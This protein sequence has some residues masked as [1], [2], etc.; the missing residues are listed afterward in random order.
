MLNEKIPVIHAFPV[1][2]PQTQTWMYNQIKYL[3]ADIEVHVVCEQTRNLE[4]FYLPRM[5][6]LKTAS[7]LRYLWEKGIRNLGVRY[8]NSYL[9]DTAKEIDCQIIHSHFGHIGWLNNGVAKK[10]KCKHVITYYGADVSLFPSRDKR[11]LT[12]YNELFSEADLFLCEGPFMARQLVKL[13][14]PI[15]KVRVHH[16]G[17]AIDNISYKPRLLGNNK[18]LRVLIAASFHE[19][20]GI[21]YAL[22]ALAKLRKTVPLEITII[23]GAS[24][25]GRSRYENNRIMDVIRFNNLGPSVRFLGYQ[26]FSTLLREAYGHHIFLSPSVTALDGDNEGGAPITIIEMMATGMPVVSTSHCDIPEVVKY[27]IDDWLVGERD[28]EGLSKRL[29]WLIDHH[30][31]WEKFLK[32]GRHHIETEFSAVRQGERLA[33]IYREILN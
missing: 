20:K 31:E 23:G 11:W 2:L 6:V 5:H 30:A 8:F 12:R 9:Y 13:G 3:P 21:P 17:I 26:P 16:L 32:L 14:C 25:E 29:Q 10:I 22:E 33:G 19:K 1:W 27:G 7:R 24:R 15:E 18:T 4:Q 28:I